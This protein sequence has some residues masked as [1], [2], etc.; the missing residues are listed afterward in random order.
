[1]RALTLTLSQGRGSEEG[2]SM[3]QEFTMQS[4][5]TERAGGTNVNRRDF[6]AGTAAALG[7]MILKSGTVRG[8]AANS[9]I[10]IGFIGCGGRGTWIADLFQRHG[11]YK[12]SGAADYFQ[13]R[14]DAFG[15]KF[16]IPASG[17]YTGLS[18]YKRLIESGVDAI[19]VES[20]PYFHPEQ[21]AAGVEAG[22]HVYL[23]KPVAVDVPGCKS[24][25]ESGKMAT[26]RKRCFLVDFQTR[27]NSLFIEAVNRVHSGAIGDFVFGE[28]TYHA[29]VPFA[30]MAKYLE[31]TPVPPEN[32]LRAWGVDRVLSRDIIT[33]QNIH[34]LDVASWIMNAPPVYAMGT[35]GCKVRPYGN[36]NDHFVVFYQY[37]DNVGISFSSRQFAGH[38]T[39]PEGI[40][41]RMFG[42][43]GVLE[44]EYGGQVLIR[45][46][47]F[48]RGG[49][50]SNIYEEGA[51]NNIAAFYNAIQ[52]G[53]YSNPTVAPSVQSNLVTLLGR[54]S[55]YEGRQLFWYQ[56]INDTEKLEFCTKGLKD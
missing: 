48:F 33:E 2:E 4:N 6:L 12:I 1:L 24:V 45:G 23:A 46:E 52:K 15:D 25:E 3:I 54:T 17:R 53:D 9:K 16:G 27:A 29:D 30:H 13:D 11:G 41:N 28:A 38:D 40:R 8:S 20:P 39:T 42:S 21:A 56:L 35:G 10:T 51:V 36:I 55:A 31:N 37:P 18:C 5:E 26:A 47:N 7:S 49:R 44:T 50:T 22:K 43:K 34:T 14:V 32:R 19:A